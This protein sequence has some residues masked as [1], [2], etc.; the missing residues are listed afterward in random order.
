MYP[1]DLKHYTY[2]QFVLMPCLVYFNIESY[3]QHVHNL[4]VVYGKHLVWAKQM[5]IFQVSHYWRIELQHNIRNVLQVPLPIQCL[6]HCILYLKFCFLPFI[7]S[8][9]IK[10][11][12][13]ETCYSKMETCHSVDLKVAESSLWCYFIHW[14]LKYL[15]HILDVRLILMF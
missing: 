4:R 1:L 13:G 6:H 15:K 5:Y 9:P 7:A 11:F 14:N 2:K 10:N 3:F 8:I 12:Y